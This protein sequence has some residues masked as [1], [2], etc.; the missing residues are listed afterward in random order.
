MPVDFGLS[1]PAGPPKGRIRRFTEDLEAILPKLQGHFKSLWMTDHFFW[2]DD[3]TYE[4]WTVISY[5]AARWPQFQVGPIVLGQTYR[6]PALLAK[7]GATL[8]MLSGGRLIMAVGAAW[9]E[10]EH[11]AYNFPYSS[12]AVR[13]EQLQD[14]LEILRRMWT[15]PG[16]VTYRG[17]HYQ[18]IDAY[19]EPKPDP[20]PPILVG[21]GGSKTMRLA[22][23]YADWWNLNDAKFSDYMERLNILKQH[24]AE[25]GRDLNSLGLSWFGRMVVGQTEAKARA[26]AG[27]WTTENAFVGTP[28]QLVEQMR[29]FVEAGVSYFM[30]EVPGLSEPDVTGMVIED[31]I[32]NLRK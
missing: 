1:L 29:Q 28:A 6:N 5:M 10:D 24:C 31:V 17:K 15:E 7:M 11:R 2:E 8:Q 12:P 9:K 19:C 30:V 13:L 27:K 4:A 16:K 21:G 23:Q 32:S 18:V 22:A 14:T 20:V 3:P 26:L 25:I